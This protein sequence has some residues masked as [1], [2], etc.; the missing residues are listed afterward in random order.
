MADEEKVTINGIDINIAEVLGDKL[1]NQ[2]FSRLSD[3]RLD[4]VMKQI[5]DLL[6]EET[7]RYGSD[8]VVVNIK[9]S[10]TDGSGYYSK[11]TEYPL[12]KYVRKE[13]SKR[14]ENL[15]QDKVNEYLATEEIKARLE[16]YTQEIIDYAIDGYKEDL[17]TRIRE[18]M[19]NNVLDTQ[20]VQQE[21][22]RSGI[23]RQEIQNIQFQMN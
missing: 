11:T 3:E 23:V 12:W 19:V 22:S 2:W 21:I 5:S 16:K 17:K 9:T 15:I 1:I 4:M 6:F 20:I 10:V 8:D 13:F 14:F 7:K 18:R